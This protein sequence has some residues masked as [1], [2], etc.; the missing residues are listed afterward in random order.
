MASAK[1]GFSMKKAA[2]I[3]YPKNSQLTGML[4]EQIHEQME[5][6]Q[7]KLIL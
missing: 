1:E 2:N 3:R 6:V 4:R 7:L 5:C